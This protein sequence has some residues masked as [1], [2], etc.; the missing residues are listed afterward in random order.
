M[1]EFQI[2]SSDGLLLKGNHWTCEKPAKAIVQLSHGMAEH[3]DRYDS[4]ARYL[5]DQGIEV[6]GHSHRGHGKTAKTKDD[7]GYLADRNGWD[8]LV[9]D[10]I[11]VSGM[12]REN[13]PDLPLFI[14]G[15]SMGSFAARNALRRQAQLYSGAVIIGSGWQYTPSI[16][17]AKSVSKMVKAVSGDRTRSKLM[18]KLLF[19]NYNNS[20]P[21][22]RTSFDWLSRDHEM[23]KEYV[24]DPYCGYLCTTSFYH[25]LITGVSRVMKT[26]G[27][28]HVPKDFPILVTSGD[29]DPVGQNGRGVKKVVDNFKRNG[30]RKVDLKL[31]P[32]G[33][34]E[35]L[36]EM[37]RM[38]VF[39]DISQWILSNI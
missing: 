13:T 23:V 20:F 32:E 35:I 15:H 37:N 31:Y 2:S 29:K 27:L 7:L 11:E 17:L 39:E 26:T 3:I 19:S 8:L 5:N 24:D 33:R 12:I 6:Y 38:I 1:K 22:S 16:H 36:N 30:L 21:N 4:F 9:N 10:L 18:D 28:E 14:L 25:D 34:H